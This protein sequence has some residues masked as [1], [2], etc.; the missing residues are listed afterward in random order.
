MEE[1]S[2]LIITISRQI[3]CGGT[4]I[5]QNIA[6]KLNLA[7]LDREIVAL[8]SEQFNL[9]EDVVAK[10]DEK[11]GFFLKVFKE[12]FNSPTTYDIQYAEAEVIQQIAKKQPTVIVG[13][14]GNFILHDH[15]KH[16]SIFL[17]ASKTF[18]QLRLLELNK[19]TVEQ[20][21]DLV[22]RTDK[23]RAKF[24]HSYAKHDITDATQYDITLDTGVL[25]VDLAEKII[26]NYIHER[27]PET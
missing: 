25:G 13:R 16:I 12:I 18:R 2:P 23:D 24:V 10:E 1:K 4:C 9:K 5:A 6:S 11:V 19:I 22:E 7:Y 14:A 8:V 27:F 26:L 20:A 15:P 3:G 17:H 21:V